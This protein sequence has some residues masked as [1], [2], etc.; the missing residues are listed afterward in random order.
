MLSKSLD[1]VQ[2]FFQGDG[3]LIVLIILSQKFFATHVHS[4][5]APPLFHSAD[6]ILQSVQEGWLPCGWPDAEGQ[7]LAASRRLQAEDGAAQPGETV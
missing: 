3:T 7:G 6:D 2:Y 1:Y 5:P 4:V